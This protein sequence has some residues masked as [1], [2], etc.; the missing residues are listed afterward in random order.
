[1]PITPPTM[2]LGKTPEEITSWFEAKGYDMSWNWQELW[3][4]EHG[5]SFTVAKVMKLDILQDIRAEVDNAVKNGETFE[6]FRRNL[7]YKLKRSGWWGRVR[8]ADVP[9]FDP[10]AGIDPDETVQLGSPWRLQT[11]YNTNINS[12]YSMGR[13]R[14]QRKAARTHPYWQY[15]AILDDHTRDEHAALHEKVWMYDDPFWDYF[16]PPNGWGCRCRVRT[17]SEKQF[18]R[19]ELKLEQTGPH[20][21]GTDRFIDPETGR[22]TKTGWFSVNGLKVSTDP[23]WSYNIGKQDW[24]VDLKRYDKD[25]VKQFKNESYKP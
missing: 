1:M 8:A 5:R 11:I 19:L 25:L 16:Y 10:A 21:F 23:A 12:A 3:Q 6:Q 22:Q 18:K 4:A 15:I 14:A 17:L 2:F 13:Y 20:N 24:T 9:G 7:E